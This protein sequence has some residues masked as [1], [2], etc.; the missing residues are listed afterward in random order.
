MCACARWPGP[1][2]TP[3]GWRAGV[4]HLLAGGGGVRTVRGEPETRGLLRGR[5]CRVVATVSRVTRIGEPRAMRQRRA[6]PGTSR[7]PSPRCP[8]DKDDALVAASGPYLFLRL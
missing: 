8:E 6:R 2:V 7:S 5:T 4:I 3:Q 1:Q